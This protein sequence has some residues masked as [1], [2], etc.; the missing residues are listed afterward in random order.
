MP[1]VGIAVAAIGIPVSGIRVGLIWPKGPRVIERHERT[2]AMRPRIV[3]AD[4][5]TFGGSSFYGEQQA[6]I[7]LNSSGI[8]PGYVSDFCSIRPRF[9]KTEC[10]ARIQVAERRARSGR[11]QSK[12]PGTAVSGN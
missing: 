6:V 8:R 5:H 11:R 12:L 1:P 3:A 2:D 9:L 10:A 7:P 4:G